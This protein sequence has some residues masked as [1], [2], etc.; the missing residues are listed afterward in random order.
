MD[1]EALRRKRIMSV[2]KEYIKHTVNFVLHSRRL[3]KISGWIALVVIFGYFVFFYMSTASAGLKGIE[4]LRRQRALRSSRMPVQSAKPNPSLSQLPEDPASKYKI[5]ELKPDFNPLYEDEEEDTGDEE[6]E[7]EEETSEGEN[8]STKD[9]STWMYLPGGGKIRVPKNK[10][11]GKGKDGAYSD[12]EKLRFMD[13]V[14]AFQEALDEGATFTR[15]WV[16][17]RFKRL[18]SFVTRK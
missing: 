15:L 8:N 16:E 13:R 10:G 12:S 5:K 4:E 18:E 11:K 7:E 17:K 1:P 3:Q 9:N 14:Q 2:I 6:D